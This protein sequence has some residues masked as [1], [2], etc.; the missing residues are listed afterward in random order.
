MLAFDDTL[1][2]GIAG[3]PDKCRTVSRKK[4]REGAISRILYDLV[5]FAEAGAGKKAR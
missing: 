4:E 3:I 2:A 1:F 5:C